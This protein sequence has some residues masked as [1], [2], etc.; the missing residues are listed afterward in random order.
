LFGIVSILDDGIEIALGMHAVNNV[1]ISLFTTHESSAFQ[2]PAVFSV[3]EMN[4][5][6][7][8]IGVIVMGAI[9]VFFFYKKYNWSFSVLNKRV[10][11]NELAEDTTL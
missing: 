11:K 8:L 9:A 2:T 7:G 10:E 5:V 1:L 6:E 4:P 3:R